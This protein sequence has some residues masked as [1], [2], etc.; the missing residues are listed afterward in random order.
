[1]GDGSACHSPLAKALVDE[2]KET[3]EDDADEADGDVRD[4]QEGILA[5]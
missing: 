3:R 2:E 1:M 5:S 4:S